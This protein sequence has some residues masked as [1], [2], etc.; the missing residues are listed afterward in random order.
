VEEGAKAAEAKILGMDK[1]TAKVLRQAEHARTG[2]ET[3][4]GGGEGEKE[5]KPHRAW[6]NEDS[7]D[8]DGTE[9]EGSGDDDVLPGGG[10]R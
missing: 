9:I 10:E 6:K 1:K 5:D 8:D 4:D 7:N 2:V 3:L